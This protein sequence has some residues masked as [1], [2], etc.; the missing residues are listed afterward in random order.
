VIIFQFAFHKSIFADRWHFY[1]PR[2]L[3]GGGFDGGNP[4]GWRVFGGAVDKAEMTT[5]RPP[6]FDADLDNLALFDA[7]SIEDAAVCVS[8]F[9]GD[10]F[11]GF[12]R[13]RD[14]LWHESVCVLPDNFWIV[15]DDFGR[16]TGL[17]HGVLGFAVSVSV[18]GNLLTI[19]LP[20]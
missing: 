15:V 1:S 11:F 5:Q 2:G 8:H 6:L 18:M 20:A 17:I 9:D 4:S 3:L 10:D 14:F 12:G 19:R 7:H 13:E 16:R